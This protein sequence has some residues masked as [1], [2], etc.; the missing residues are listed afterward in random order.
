MQR[1]SRLK[2]FSFRFLFG[3][4]EQAE[5]ARL[6][7]GEWRA[8]RHSPPQDPTALKICSGG[9]LPHFLLQL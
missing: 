5:K 2:D 1:L 9:L 4:Y 7:G 8:A 3:I 6:Q